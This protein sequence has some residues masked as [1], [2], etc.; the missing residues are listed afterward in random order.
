MVQFDP[1]QEPLVQRATVW[2]VMW[3][4]RGFTSAH[5]V[6]IN[7]KILNVQNKQAGV[8]EPIVFLDI[9]HLGHT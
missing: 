1:V 9:R 2:S 8:K 3:S 5:L 4:E 6:W 7:Q